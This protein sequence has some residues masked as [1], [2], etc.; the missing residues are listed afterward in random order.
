MVGNGFGSSRTSGKGEEKEMVVFEGCKGLDKVGD[1]L[2]ASA[3]LLGNGC[4]GST[5]RVV[6]DGGDVVVAKIVRGRTKKKEVDDWLRLI[7][8][9]KHSNIVSLRAYHHSYHQLLLVYDFLPNGSLHSLLHGNRGPE[10][11]IGVEHKDKSSLRFCARPCIPAYLQ[12]S[13]ALPW[14]PDII[15]HPSRSLGQ[16]LYN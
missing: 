9:M 11:H 3:E 14:T 1:L 5:Y 6:M 2:K 7:D 15:K 4:M 10:E 8:G 13:E 16:R 12:Q